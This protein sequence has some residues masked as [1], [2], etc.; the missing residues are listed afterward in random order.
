MSRQLPLAFIISVTF[1]ACAGCESAAPPEERDVDFG[2]PVAARP[3][4]RPRP[5]SPEQPTEPSREPSR[6]PAAA[7]ADQADETPKEEKEPRPVESKPQSQPSAQEAAAEPPP[8]T[9]PS[10]NR[11]GERRGSQGAQQQSDPVFPGREG[12][13]KPATAVDAA[14]AGRRKLRSASAAAQRGDR[15]AA[16]RLALDACSLVGAHAADDAACR[17]VAEEAERLIERTGSRPAGTV[18]PTRFE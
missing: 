15:Q 10:A 13:G 7:E 16:C 4:S 1:L 9:P 17:Q 6:P 5:A 12:R 2:R 14:A 18:G 3:R 8:A 11:G